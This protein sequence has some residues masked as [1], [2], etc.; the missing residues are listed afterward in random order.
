M[1]HNCAAQASHRQALELR[2]Q[3][4]VQEG[5]NELREAHLAKA[6]FLYHTGAK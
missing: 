6:E 2:R 3:L 5:E 1:L 4:L